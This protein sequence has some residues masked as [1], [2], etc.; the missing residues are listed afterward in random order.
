MNGQ[1][2]AL[3]MG[4]LT[5]VYVALLANTGLTLMQINE[6][7]AR[8]MGVLILVFPAFAIWLTILEFKFGVQMERLTKQVE[9][10][11]LWPDLKFEFRPSG[12]PTRESAIAVFG[13][14]AKKVAAD[15]S[16]YLSWFAL[17]LAYDAAGDRRRARASMR[18]AIK[19]N[20]G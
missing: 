3:V 10:S 12:R 7:V 1:F 2:S 9:A 18:R 6:V 5:L 19:L 4:V 8:V 16:N 14:Y 17:G 13:D 11:G 20:R 15:E